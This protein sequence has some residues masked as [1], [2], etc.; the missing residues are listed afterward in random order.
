MFA[1]TDRIIANIQSL[2]ETSFS[3]ED[4]RVDDNIQ[5]GEDID[6]FEDVNPRQFSGRLRRQQR[7][8]YDRR[9]PDRHRHNTDVG[10]VSRCFLSYILNRLVL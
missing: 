6:A 8:S 2:A 5:L 3:E 4:S 9:K 7:G 10:R 1:H